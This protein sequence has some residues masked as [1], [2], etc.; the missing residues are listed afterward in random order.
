MTE[1]QKRTLLGIDLTSRR[2]LWNTLDRLGDR[3]ASRER[4][5]A[6][7]YQEASRRQA[8]IGVLEKQAGQFVAERNEA[9]RRAADLREQLAEADRL[10]DELAEELAGREHMYADLAEQLAAANRANADFEA[11]I[12]EAELC[13]KDVAQSAMPI[14]E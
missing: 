1:L 12:A 8:R 14:D 3:L 4:M 9:D 7:R 5:L 11:R 10:N 2:E 6:D 13:R